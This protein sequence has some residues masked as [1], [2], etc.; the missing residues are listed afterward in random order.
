M[1]HIGSRLHVSPGKSERKRAFF[2]RPNGHFHRHTQIRVQRL[3]G[4]GGIK[5][6]RSDRVGVITKGWGN[7]LMGRARIVVQRYFWIGA[8]TVELADSPATWLCLV[9]SSNRRL[10]CKK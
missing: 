6:A 10:F 3:H 7:P 2:E 5:V 8:F 9:G 4:T 1:M